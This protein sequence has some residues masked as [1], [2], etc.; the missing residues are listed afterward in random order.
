MEHIF[1]TFEILPFIKASFLKLFCT[2][3]FSVIKLIIVCVCVCVCVVT[4]KQMQCA[5]LEIS[6]HRQLKKWDCSR[7]R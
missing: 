4:H 5:T 2:D 1:V 6:E 3:T 7:R